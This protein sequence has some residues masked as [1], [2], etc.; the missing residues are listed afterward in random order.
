MELRE[1]RAQLGDTQSEFAGR[2]GI[3]FRTVQNWEAGIRKPPEY[4]INLLERRVREDMVNRKTISL[5]KYDP[6]KDNL[7]KRRDFKGSVA[8]LQ[9]VRDC[10]GNDVVFALDEA[11]M[12]QGSFLGRFNMAMIAFPA[13][14]A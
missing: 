12:C 1:L 6:K 8:W 2:Y 10:I 13:T 7:P 11:L 4:M 5:P 14:T 3:P 9:A